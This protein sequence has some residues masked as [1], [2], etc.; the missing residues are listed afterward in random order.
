MPG[1]LGPQE[2]QQELELTVGE[3]RASVA[4]ETSCLCAPVLVFQELWDIFFFLAAFVIY[5]HSR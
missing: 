4:R 1:E 5:K 2:A 3:G